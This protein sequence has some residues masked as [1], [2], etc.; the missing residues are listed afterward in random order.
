MEWLIVLAVA[1][2]IL[3][4]TSRSQGIGGFLSR[5]L[6]RAFPTIDNRLLT[7]A[8]AG[9][10]VLGLISGGLQLA[11]LTLL[12]YVV[13]LGVGP[14]TGGVLLRTRW[15]VL[16]A[17]IVSVIIGAGGEIRALYIALPVAMIAYLGVRMEWVRSPRDGAPA[18]GRG[19][20]SPRV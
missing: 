18:I 16:V 1:A 3:V 2:G 13:G 14:F 12:A 4:W 7:R 20:R 19:K 9:G 17:A 15:W 5:A 11:G 8:L 6:L 10:V